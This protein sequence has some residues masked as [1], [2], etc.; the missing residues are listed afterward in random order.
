M[1]AQAKLEVRY[2]WS[3]RA[4]TACRDAR[5]LTQAELGARAGLSQGA[6]TRFENHRGKPTLI[7][8]AQL[9]DALE[10]DAGELFKRCVLRMVWPKPREMRPRGRHARR[11]S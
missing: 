11:A 6:I 10:L 1:S 2:V 7:E 5:G 4:L 8:F 3:G 9:A